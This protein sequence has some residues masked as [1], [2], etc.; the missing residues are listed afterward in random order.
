MPSQ[1]D[2]LSERPKYQRF[3]SVNSEQ[4][5][6]LEHGVA[7]DGTTLVQRKCMV[8]ECGRSLFLVFFVQGPGLSFGL[9]FLSCGCCVLIALGNI[10]RDALRLYRVFYSIAINYNSN[11]CFYV[12]SIYLL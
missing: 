4:S 10:V 12:T 11:T 1:K 5:L 6:Y 9:L 7:L 8:V 2:P 3:P